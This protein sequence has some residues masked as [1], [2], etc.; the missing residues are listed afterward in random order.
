MEK[1]KGLILSWGKPFAHW[2]I[3]TVSTLKRIHNTSF[4][5]KLT[6]WKSSCIVHQQWWGGMTN[7]MIPTHPPCNQHQVYLRTRNV[8]HHCKM[9]ALI[10]YMMG[11]LRNKNEKLI[12]FRNNW[13]SSIASDV[14][15][16]QCTNIKEGEYDP[17]G[18]FKSVNSCCLCSGSY[19]AGNK[20]LPK[21]WGKWNNYNRRLC[22][23][24]LKRLHYL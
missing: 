9:S 19:L 5:I 4:F 17:T 20:M 10:H 2:S 13:L 18:Q 6:H 12:T 11:W 24:I 15:H 1:G 14:E 21:N 3:S 23:M 7:K 16:F 22:Q 8:C